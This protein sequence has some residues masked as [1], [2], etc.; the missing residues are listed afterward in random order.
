MLIPDLTFPTVVYGRQQKRHDLSELIHSQKNSVGPTESEL[1]SLAPTINP[2]RLQLI[3]NIHGQLNAEITSGGSVY[4]LRQRIL[5]IRK[6]FKWADNSNQA[7]SLETVVEAFKYWTDELLDEERRRRLKPESLY[8]PAYCVSAILTKMLDRRLPLIQETRIRSTWIRPGARGIKADKQSLEETF[9]FGRLLLDLTNGLGVESIFGPLPITIK[10]LNNQVY[11][12]WLLLRPPENLR[13]TNCPSNEA[14]NFKRRSDFESDRSKRRRSPMI[15]LRLDAELLMF[16]AQTGMNFAQAYK[17]RNGAFHY[18]SHMDGYQ[19]RLYKNRRGGDVEFEIHGE[20][21][22]IFE[23]YLRW[24]EELFPDQPDG[25]LF[26]YINIKGRADDG[27]P[28]FHQLKKVCARTATKFIGPRELRNT[29]INWLLRRSQDPELT[30]ELAQHTAETLIYRYQRPNLQVAMVEIAKFHASTDP[31]LSPPGPGLCASPRPSPRSDTPPN[32]PQPDCIAPG[33]CLFCSQHRDID[34]ADYMWSLASF[35]HLKSLELMRSTQRTD[36]VNPPAECA[37]ERAS[38]KLI[39]IA[40]SSEVRRLWVE[41]A[42]AKVF[43]GD[44][45]PA[46]DGFIQLQEVQR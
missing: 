24:R 39:E 33:G 1:Y 16:I 17:V 32:A 21:K 5:A 46:W 2:E 23:N 6:F 13:P 20:Y 15:H 4:T 28:R 30:A 45:H 31:H 9:T 40:N 44:Y 41:E 27:P 36:Q 25:L 7:L 26:P 11:E 34:S 43:E 18:T 42:H 35:R 22:E 3:E 8:K 19:V 29:R 10:L 14:R 12:D 38:S 37:V